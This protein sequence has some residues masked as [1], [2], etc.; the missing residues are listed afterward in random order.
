MKLADS[1]L[2]VSEIE[3]CIPGMQ[4][5]E[6]R[7]IT[8]GWENLVLEVN[9]DYMFRFPMMRD[10]WARLQSEMA[11]LPWLSRQLTIP[12]PK[13]EFVWPGNRKYPWKLAGYRKI[14]GDPCT[15]D[16]F[17]QEW[18]S[19]LG[20]DLGHF[21]TELHN[22]SPPPRGS[23]NSIPKYNPKTWAESRLKF[24]RRVRS[25]AYPLLDV[26]MRRWAEDFWEKSLDYFAKADFE[27][28]L[29]H[30]ALRGG[31][32]I[33]EP[34]TGKLTGIID[35]EHAAVGDPALDFMGTFEINRHLGQQALDNYRR[36]KSG[37]L[38]RV[39]LYLQTIPFGEIAWGVQ[40]GAERFTRMGLRHIR[41]G[42]ARN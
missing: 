32:I 40:T 24:Y 42:L 7:R 26:R 20:A 1:R 18:T 35:W 38:R 33:F 19:R 6:Y 16:V 10:G 3:A 8:T 22:A 11:F 5:K 29:I 23:S 17:R 15:S 21:I 27:P 37:F 28:T 4:V 39:E 14:P 25:L 30:S 36:K 9:G 41:N 34:T 31:N 2:L 13:Y 12:I